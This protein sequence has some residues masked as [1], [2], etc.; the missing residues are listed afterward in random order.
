[1]HR[2][3]GIVFQHY[4]TDPVIRTLSERI[5]RVRSRKSNL[6]LLVVDVIRSSILD[7]ELPLGSKLENENVLSEQ[8]DVSRA[9]L[10]EA[11]R[12]LVHEGFVVSRRGIGTF[13]RE[14]PAPIVKSGLERMSSTT[15]LIRLTGST[16]STRD[17]SWALAR[18]PLE[19]ALALGVQPDAEL[20]VITRTRLIDEQPLMW[21][22]EY[23]PL[24]VVGASSLLAGFD[25][26]SLYAFLSRSIGLRITHCECR[27]TAAKASPEVAG[28]L[29]VVPGDPL[30]VL[31]Q[32]HF[33]QR[34]DAV[35]F[36][37]NHHNAALMDFYLVRQEGAL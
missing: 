5:D 15:D 32:L 12:V 27:I 36:S 20:A 23:L 3:G 6:V 28:I 25:G 9:T 10:R 14:R 29:E 30:L 13:I 22:R 33:D 8:L 21:T 11:I 2:L 24:S 35:L 18:P 34:G 4:P 7:G 19:V 37:I 17:Y 16:P 1:M 31:K 26:Q